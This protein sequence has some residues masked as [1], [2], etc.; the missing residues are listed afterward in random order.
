MLLAFMSAPF[1][2]W[3]GA[4]TNLA[5][6]ILQI[7][8]EIVRQSKT[9]IVLDITVKNVGSQDVLIP[10]GYLPWDRYAM[11]LVLVETDPSSTPLKQELV[12]ADPMPGELR[13]LKKGESM[14]GNIDLTDRFPQLS[15][16]LQRTE[17]I[18]FWSYQVEGETGTRFERIAGW[19]LIPKLPSPS[20]K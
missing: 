20:P 9:N 1:I 7:E 14:R 11:T 8:A 19:K 12:I 3:S 10:D 4:S 18:V 6:G 15:K 16:V 2:A 17:V 5:N 13:K